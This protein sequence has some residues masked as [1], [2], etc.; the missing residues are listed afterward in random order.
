M[1][2]LA[3]SLAFS[4]SLLTTRLLRT[5]PDIVLVSA[6]FAGG[7]AFGLAIR[8]CRLGHADMEQPW[9]VFRRPA[10]FRPALCCASTVR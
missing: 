6:Q 4:C 3:G 1:I 9:V 5:T 7:L 8:A 10:R 2:A